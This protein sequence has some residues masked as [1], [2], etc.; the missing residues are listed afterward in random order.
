MDSRLRTSCRPLLVLP[1]VL[2]MASY[3]F[4]A[5]GTTTVLISQQTSVE[6]EELTLLEAIRTTIA[7]NAQLR[8]GAVY[9]EIAKQR[10]GVQEGAFDTLVTASGGATGAEN[11]TPISTS[12]EIGIDNEAQSI[13]G[14]LQRRL[15][16][17]AVL[18]FN[19]ESQSSGDEAMGVRA[20]EFGSTNAA[21]T[22]SYPLWR[23]RG[24]YL[25][26]LNVGLAELEF[27]ATNYDLMHRTDLS[28]LSTIRNYWNYRGA[29]EA[30]M[31]LREAERRSESLLQQI[32]K[33]VDADELT[34][35]EIGVIEAQV[36]RRTGAR[37]GG[38]SR[39]VQA[40]ASLA[41]DLGVRLILS[42][43]SH[44]PVTELPAPYV[45]QS[46]LTSLSGLQI[47]SYIQQNRKDFR[48]LD[49]RMEIADRSLDLA[50][51]AT[52]PSLDLVVASQYQTFEQ[53]N[54]FLGNLGAPTYGPNWSV[55]LNYNWSLN[56]VSAKASQRIAVLGR[57]QRK[58][59]RAE[60]ARDAEV[61]FNAA[62]FSLLQA[63]RGY[64]EANERLSLSIRNVK[65]GRTKFLLDE[66]TLLDV[67]NVEDQ[68]L[69]AQVDIISQRVSY[70]N[71]LVNA[72]FLTGYLSR[73]GADVMREPNLKRADLFINELN[74]SV[75]AAP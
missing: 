61:S 15:K 57:E 65:K 52:K 64:D 16:S 67:L 13:S 30:L 25:T 71:A 66:S 38:E 42:P 44:K 54:Q 5:S 45:E 40:Q 62:K 7:N 17:G 47:Q 60:L 74:K 12:E 51:D 20:N 4:G 27:E 34:R 33:L 18:N 73:M 32:V 39:L 1:F 23:G 9:V 43:E 37:L 11:P 8:V 29:S 55:R 53:D 28:V 10:I 59:E 21:L 50:A 70:A 63:Y 72:M 35:A 22:I 41:T 2:A 19:I 36:S 58:I 3:S 24:E 26:T 6:S 68:L 46:D 56:Q 69:Q 31:L 75:T 49:G 48:A 14:G